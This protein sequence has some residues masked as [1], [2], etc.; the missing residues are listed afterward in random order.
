M[1]VNC[2]AIP[3][4]L[5]ESEFFGHV[6]GA[7][8]G[9][10]ASRAGL[11]EAADGGTLFLDEV[12]DLSPK[13]QSLLLRALQQSEFRRLGD[14]RL[15][16]SDFRLIAATNRPLA[17]LVASGAFR[18]DLFY[19]LWV[20]RLFLPPLRERRAELARIA[21]ALLRRIA[22]RHRIRAPRLSPTALE[23]LGASSWPGNIRELEAVLG[24]ALLRR[25]E[26][27]TLEPD[28]F[29]ELDPAAPASDA[30]APP[31]ATRPDPPPA[32]S[33]AEDAAAFTD[34]LD[35]LLEIR[36]LAAAAFAFERLA[37]RRALARADGRR[38]AAAHELGITRQALWRKLRRHGLG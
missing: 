28:D 30:A 31:E 19:R 5:L 22:A 3:D 16:R 29:R 15:R 34:R 6:R 32:E 25:P 18:R 10:A 35:A 27:R 38:A 13:G 12:G 14:T 36:R 23:T 24:G 26:A 1:A 4:E 7:F 11:L 33:P 8:T 20:A 17:S 9:A 37:L 21:D 2:A